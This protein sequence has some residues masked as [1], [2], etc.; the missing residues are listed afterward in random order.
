[1]EIALWILGA[2]IFVQLCREIK[3]GDFFK[4]RATYY[5]TRDY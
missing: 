3:S 1:M 4:P 5:V 2:L